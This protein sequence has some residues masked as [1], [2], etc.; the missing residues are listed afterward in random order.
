M[1]F[2]K[3]QHKTSYTNRK[4]LRKYNG[5]DVVKY[6][7]N[8][9]N[10][11][12][13]RILF[14]SD[15]HIQTKNFNQQELI[16]AINDSEADWLILGGDLL[17]LLYYSRTAN[18]FLKQLY[19]KNEKIAIL[20]NWESRRLPWIPMSIWHNYF[21]NAGFNLLA[22]SSL[23]SKHTAFSGLRPCYS[24][25]S[26]I[27]QQLSPDK[28]NCLIS[29]KPDD[30]FPLIDSLKNKPELI[31]CGHTHGGQLR[32]PIFGALYTSS[33]YW[34]LFEYGHYINKETS[35]NLIVSSGLGFT[36]I[37]KRIFCRPEIL[38]IDFQ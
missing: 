15:L 23:Y 38:L 11:K 24:D 34:K 17:S 4:V 16:T 20:G 27:D 7:I 6:R 28:F 5:F 32:I 9:V 8:S 30:L 37:Q 33:K 2:R 18:S 14:F 3:W 10:L 29:H 26:N 22:N 35:T 12:N 31:L 21:E 25:Y 1:I 19:A 36:G 13:K